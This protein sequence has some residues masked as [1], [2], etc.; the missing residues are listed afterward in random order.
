M[1]YDV[2]MD[3]TATS[4]P[5]NRRVSVRRT[6]AS[7]HTELIVLWHHDSEMPV[8]YRI[9]DSSRG[10]FCLRSSVPMKTGMTGHAVRLLPQGTTMEKPIMI[11]WAKPARDGHGYEL[12]LRFITPD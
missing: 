1:L 8:R 11:V 12:G 3:R 10:G 2:A 6:H 5:E 9:I 4:L 7:S